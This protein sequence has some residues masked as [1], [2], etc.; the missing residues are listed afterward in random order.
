MRVWSKNVGHYY[1]Y[2]YLL[3]FKNGSFSGHLRTCFS[4]GRST[5]KQSHNINSVIQHKYKLQVCVY[6]KSCRRVMIKNRLEFLASNSQT[7]SL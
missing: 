4:R 7:F 5:R 2:Y 1:Y 3:L 6:N